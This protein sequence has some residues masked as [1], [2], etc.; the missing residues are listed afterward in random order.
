MF[1]PDADDPFISSNKKTKTFFINEKVNCGANF[2]IK[3]NNYQH[4]SCLSIIQTQAFNNN[5]DS[6][7]IHNIFLLLLIYKD[8]NTLIFRL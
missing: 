1:L 2:P 6:S 4:N 8:I 5:S 3:Y 7:C